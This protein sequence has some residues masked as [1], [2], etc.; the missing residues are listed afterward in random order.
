[1]KSPL[2]ATDIIIEYDNGEVVLIERGNEPF[3][4]QFA[5]PGGMVEIG[6]TVENAAV[7]EAKEETGLDIEIIKLLGVYS[8]PARDPRGH[9]VSIVFHARPI[10]GELKADSDAA[11]AIRTSDYLKIDLAFDHNKI[12]RD[13]EISR[14]T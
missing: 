2:L 9:C 5:I 10:G 7:R 1:M 4:G 12:I 3:K 6:E 11:N 8:D 14:K 13:F